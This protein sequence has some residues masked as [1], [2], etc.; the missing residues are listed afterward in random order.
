MQPPEKGNLAKNVYVKIEKMEGEEHPKDRNRP[1]P[2]ANS[3]PGQKNPAYTFRRPISVGSR[4]YERQNNPNAFANQGSGDLAG[5]NAT[6]ATNTQA[7]MAGYNDRRAKAQTQKAEKLATFEQKELDDKLRKAEQELEYDTQSL[8]VKPVQDELGPSGELVVPHGHAAPLPKSPARNSSNKLNMFSGEKPIFDY[9]PEAAPTKEAISTE[10]PT[11][12]NP[13]GF[14]VT[15]TPPVFTHDVQV[16]EPTPTQN[17]A[18]KTE[19]P[20]TQEPDIYETPLESAERNMRPNFFPSLF[21]NTRKSLAKDRGAGGSLRDAEKNASNQ[22]SSYGLDAQTG[23]NEI[24][25]DYINN[26]GKSNEDDGKKRVKSGFLKKKGPLATIIISLLFGGGGM[27]MT[28]SALPFTVL[29]KLNDSFDSQNVSVNRRSNVFTRLMAKNAK[30][31]DAGSGAVKKNL[32]GKSK[33]KVSSRMKKRMR[34]HNLNIITDKNSPNVGKLEFTDEKGNKKIFTPEEFEGAYKSNPEVRKAYDAA[35]HPW[36]TSVSNF[37]D[38][39]FKKIM[40]K[41]GI[42]KR[43]LDGYD[44][45]ND[46]TGEKARKQLAEQVEDT[47]EDGANN[48]KAS[49][50]ENDDEGM[51]NDESDNDPNNANKTEAEKGESKAAAISGKL[52]KSLKKAFQITQV[53]CIVPTIV[54]GATLIAQAYQ[55]YQVVKIAMLFMSGVDQARAGDAASSPI[56]VL[57]RSLVEQSSE[58]R[59]TSTFSAESDYE[60]S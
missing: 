51:L 36:K 34:K 22:D 35:A 9:I 10:M 48:K 45:S 49:G 27:Y 37:L 19:A 39:G 40:N 53:V 20:Q 4:A 2:N 43:P 42:K 56:N 38:K 12:S 16:T 44:P 1:Q 52:S 26:V 3:Q 41:F 28:Q 6:Q 60:E 25:S 32:F 11:P 33:F 54:T 23:E 57:G 31:L 14:K 46:P 55:I 21:R 58:R 50:G 17:I 7:S 8:Q 30:N 24:N 18:Q 47:F 15:T 5:R 29:D 13:V 59:F